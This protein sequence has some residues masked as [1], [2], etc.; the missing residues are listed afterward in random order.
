MF[1][2]ALDKHQVL[3]IIQV[4]SQPA[5]LR[6]SS[7]S[8]NDRN[9]E[10]KQRNIASQLEMYCQSN[11]NGNLTEVS[12]LSSFFKKESSHPNLMDIIF[13]SRHSFNEVDSSD[14]GLSHQKVSHIPEFEYLPS[15]SKQYR[16]PMMQSKIVTK[17]APERESNYHKMSEVDNEQCETNEPSTLTLEKNGSYGQCRQIEMITEEALKE[18]EYDMHNLEDNPISLVDFSKTQK[19]KY[20]EIKIEDAFNMYFS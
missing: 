11:Y 4:K 5:Q 9:C 13:P 3:S 1:S 19:S 18:K 6:V 16:F 2:E 15:S 20:K 17:A 12:D 10:L 7:S 14:I 8:Q